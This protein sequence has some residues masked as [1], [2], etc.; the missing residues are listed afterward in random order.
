MLS[1]LLSGV[2]QGS[3]YLPEIHDVL[4]FPPPMGP[5]MSKDDEEI[6]G[7]LGQITD[8][9]K[10]AVRERLRIYLEERTKSS[11]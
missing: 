1:E 6:L 11:K 10:A 3:T 9:Q 2:R 8:E 4:G 5:L 7:A